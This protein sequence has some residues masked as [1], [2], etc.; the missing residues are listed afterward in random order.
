[1]NWLMTR[2]S[3]PLAAA[4]GPRRSLCRRTWNHASTAHSVPRTD[5]LEPVV[6]DVHVQGRSVGPR[7][8]VRIGRPGG[9]LNHSFVDRR[10]GPGAGR[11]TAWTPAPFFRFFSRSLTSARPG[12]RS[13]RSG[14]HHLGSPG[15]P[16]VD[17]EREQRD[18]RSRPSPGRVRT[19]GAFAHLLAGQVEAVPEPLSSSSGVT[20]PLSRIV[21]I[22]AMVRNGSGSRSLGIRSFP[23]LPRRVDRDQF[24]SRMAPDPRVAEA[25]SAPCGRCRPGCGR[26]TFLPCVSREPWP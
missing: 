18:R 8:P 22:S 1:M 2:W 15:R 23:Q 5:D 25:T 14:R 10:P 26:F 11:P 4:P 17:A 6:H 19:G 24:H 12:S 16:G 13:H 9:G 3:T 21:R 20:P 7:G